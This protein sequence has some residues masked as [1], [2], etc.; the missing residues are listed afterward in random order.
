ML[1]LLY[2]YLLYTYAYT[3]DSEQQNKKLNEYTLQIGNRKCLAKVT[4]L[5]VYEY[6]THIRTNNY[7]LTTQ[8]TIDLHMM[9]VHNYVYIA[10]HVTH[11]H[12]LKGLMR[13]TYVCS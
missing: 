1:N 9:Y 2:V 4:V 10:L 6:G 8:T 13:N 5:F 12:N 7:V 11:L 3:N